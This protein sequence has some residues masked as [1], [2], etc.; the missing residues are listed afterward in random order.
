MNKIP[1]MKNYQQVENTVNIIKAKKRSAFQ[2]AY[3][4]DIVNRS[5]INI[6]LLPQKL[7]EL[8]IS[9]GNKGNPYLAAHG[10][11][12]EVDVFLKEFYGYTISPEEFSK[13]ITFIKNLIPIKIEIIRELILIKTNNFTKKPHAYTYTPEEF[14][15]WWSKRIPESPIG[16]KLEDSGHLICRLPYSISLP[17]ITAF[18]VNNGNTPVDISLIDCYIFEEDEIKMQKEEMKNFFPPEKNHRNNQD[19]KKYNPV[20]SDI[21]NLYRHVHKKETKDTI[22]EYF[23]H[24]QDAIKKISVEWIE[25]RWKG[26][27]AKNAL[28][29]IFKFISCEEQETFEN[30]LK[31]LDTGTSKV[32]SNN[33]T[34]AIML[35][36]LCVERRNKG[37]RNYKGSDRLKEELYNAGISNGEVRDA[38][39]SIV[40]NKR[41]PNDDK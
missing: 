4:F 1:I 38:I 25:A 29:Q 9:T 40:N 37:D 34:P 23:K 32:V 22:K 30:A 41:E 33:T 16:S 28:K 21:K 35:I 24:P 10:I 7:P 11:I 12:D 3:F 14:R 19:G 36:E 6:A 17:D 27:L 13:N 26:Q 31:K 39:Y 20:I 8:S 18:H 2:E 15:E 5:S